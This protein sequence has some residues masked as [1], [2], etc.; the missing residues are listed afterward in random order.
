MNLK[1]KYAKFQAIVNDCFLKVGQVLWGHG[2]LVT[3]YEEAVR[4]ETDGSGEVDATDVD[5][6][7]ISGKVDPESVQQSD[8][9]WN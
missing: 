7:D 6:V 5:F 9:D 3:A 2:Y 1:Q 4:F 8:I